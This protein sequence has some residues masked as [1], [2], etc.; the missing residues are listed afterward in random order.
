MI[1]HTRA[2]LTLIL[3]IYHKLDDETKDVVSLELRRIFKG[4]DI[5]DRLKR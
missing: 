5:G 2:L 4:Y 1:S 3:G